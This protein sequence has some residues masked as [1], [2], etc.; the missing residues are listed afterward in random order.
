AAE[1]G[2]S[3]YKIIW[4][5]PENAALKEERKNPNILF[6][7][8]RVFIPDREVRL[9]PRPTD[10]LHVFELRTTELRLKL[11][12]EDLYEKP[13][14][15]TPCD[16]V[17]PGQTRRV[18][19]DD[20][21]RLDEVIPADTHNATLFVRGP[22]TP[23]QDLAIPIRVGHLDPIDK[24]TGQA[25]RLMNL[26]YYFGPMDPVDADDFS[27]AVEEFQCDHGL[28]VDGKCGPNTQSTLKKV[29]GS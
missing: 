12:L 18:T 11:V 1:K 29:H 27:S 15:S 22:E 26:G 17:L 19:T 7:G 23:F 24:L 2:F 5:H 4:D 25:A 20:A 14:A 21:G 8:D 13:I 10:Q 3:D 9:E 6:P 28:A 16:L